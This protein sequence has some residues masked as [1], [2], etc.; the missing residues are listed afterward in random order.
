KGTY[1]LKARITG[2]GDREHLLPS[3]KGSFEFSARDGEFVRSGG[4]DATFDY[5]N[6]TGDFKVEF[7]DL[8]RLA[9]PYRL[10]AV[11]GSIDGE[12]LAA[13]EVIVQS[14]QLDLSGQGKVDLARKQIDGKALVAVLRPVNEV[15]REIPLVGSIFGGSLLA[16]PVRVTGSLER[17][18][19]AYLSPQDVGME[20]L[21]VP[22]RILGLPMGAIRLFTPAG[23]AGDKTITK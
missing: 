10:V 15:I 12:I 2:R 19:V 16:I 21:N 17:P 13:D 9:F 22:M 5:L 18:N 23:D 4:M 14:S 7:P 3:L 8:D 6:A 11:K 1:S 20:L